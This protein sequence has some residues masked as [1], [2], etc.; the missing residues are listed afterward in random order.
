M[1]GSELTFY[2]TAAELI[3]YNQILQDTVSTLEDPPGTSLFFRSAEFTDGCEATVSILV[4]VPRPYL[5]IVLYD[6]NGV[7]IAG[8]QRATDHLD[9]EFVFLPENG[10]CYTVKIQTKP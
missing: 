9:Q 2:I 8:E 3:R 1:R 7:P 6:Q 10:N 5:D 4:G